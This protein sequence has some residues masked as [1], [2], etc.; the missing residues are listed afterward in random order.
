MHRSKLITYFSAQPQS[1]LIPEVFPSPFANDPHPLAKTAA[2]QLQAQLLAA[3]DVLN[4]EKA[5]NNGKMFG[6]LV[7]RDMH[8]KLGFLSA[9]SGMQRGD[10]LVAGF[11][12]PIFA[13][14]EQN[15][16]LPAAQAEAH[17]INQQ[18]QKLET[19]LQESGLIE[20]L[21]ELKQSRDVALNTLKQRHKQEKEARK[22]RRQALQADSN[23]SET[24]FQTEMAALALASQ[25]HKY[26]ARHTAASWKIKIQELER[27]YNVFAQEIMA[28]KDLRVERSRQL[29]GQIFNSYRLHNFAGETQPITDFFRENSD[30]VLP[31]AGAGDCAGAKL[32]HYAKLHQLQPLA[33]AEFW[34]GASPA[35]GVRHHGQFY[36]ACRGKCRPILPFMLGGL[37]VEPEPDYGEGIDASEPKIIY[38]DDDLI[39]INKPSGLMSTPGKT[40][41]DSV[42]VRLAQ[43]YPNL[44]EL[45]LV[46]RLDMDT[47]GLLLVAKNLT[48]NKYLQQQFVQRSIEKRYEALLSKALPANETEGDIDLPLR[49]DFDDR[50]RQLVCYEYGKAAQTHWQVMNIEGNTTRV[51]FYPHTGRT[52]QLRVHASHRD[53]LHAAIV[54]DDLYGLAGGRLMLHAQRLCFNHPTTHERLE[55]EIPAPF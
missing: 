2:A 9:F 39:V 25:H 15:T 53:G 50:P 33:M 7:V 43:R 14:D 8:G 40:I 29:H 45:R 44:P 22:Q 37:D 6:V 30:D 17:D 16:F 55:F 26:E 21:K 5:A 18:L 4:D 23:I 48:A 24:T 47:S 3:R 20:Q 28:L 52:H 35:A 13:V 41:K 1:E 42:A 54:G 36:P 11:V 32:I 27:A 51:Y 49:V 10:W 34:W 46:H 19:S 12:P 38:E 31:P